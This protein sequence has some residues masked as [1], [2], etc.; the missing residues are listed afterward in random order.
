MILTILGEECEKLV[1]ISIFVW[2]NQPFFYNRHMSPFTTKPITQEY[3]ENLSPLPPPSRSD[4]S[5]YKVFMGVF[6]WVL[7]IIFLGNLVY[8][9]VSPD[10]SINGEKNIPPNFVD[11]MTS[12]ISG[13]FGG[14]TWDEKGVTYIL[15]TGKGGEG[16]DGAD[17]TDTI[18]VAGLDSQKKT[19]SLISIP[20]DLYVATG[21]TSASR[22]NEL[23]SIGKAK[24]KWDSL[25][26]EKIT[27]I[28]GLKIDYSIMIDFSWFK[29]V[30]DILGGIEIDVPEDLV[31]REFPDDNWWYTKLTIRKW[32]QT[33]DGKTAL[34]YA[35][36]RHSTSDFSRSARQQLLIKVIK[37]KVLSSGIYNP[38]QIVDL[39]HSI[40]GNL[41]TDIPIASM[42]SL[43]MQAK[44][45]PAENIQIMNLN[46]NCL[47]I[48]VCEVGSFLYNPSRDLFGG[49]SVLV[50]E[51]ATLSK[52]SY[53]E[54]TRR[55]SYLFFAFPNLHKQSGSLKIITGT[56]NKTLGQ[57]ALLGLKKLW[58]PIENTTNL[59][60]TTGAIENSHINIYWNKEHTIWYPP[61]SEIVQALKS[62]FPT[63]T[64][65]EVMKNEYIT[66][67]GPQ[68]EIVL[69]AD[70][71]KQTVFAERPYYIPAPPPQ[72]TSTGD[73]FS[74]MILTPKRKPQTPPQSGSSGGTLSMP[75]PPTSESPLPVN[76]TQNIP[77]T[78]LTPQGDTPN[79]QPWQ[80]EN[81]G[82]SST[83]P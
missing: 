23:Y 26:R 50:P 41:E 47:S 32:L 67:D 77:T 46:N 18:M 53:Y 15:L 5:P 21:N 29:E 83:M 35:R 78:P 71:A 65:V 52:L 45:V 11:Q 28:T 80:W 24:G 64:F 22:I 69:G 39:F 44:E 17:L 2:N 56:K 20:R 74:D 16:H 55:L 63:M 76:E 10:G 82:T 9:Y 34:A 68:I 81:F 48:L 62:I 25:L 43:A 1:K 38:S 73:V 6:L 12:G 30:V 70:I 31:D 75:T 3:T 59:V 79:I 49:A 66:N 13:I 37:E 72:P 4:A 51:N 54:D 36:S 27:E 14:T 58:F 42:I 8:G 33:F 7:A 57:N 60:F 61:D 19:I 40:Q